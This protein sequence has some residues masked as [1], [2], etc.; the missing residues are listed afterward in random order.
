L[1]PVST[2]IYH[3][4]LT[5]CFTGTFPIIYLLPV[6]DFVFAEVP[7]SADS[8]PKMETIVDMCTAMLILVRDGLIDPSTISGNGPTN[9][10]DMWGNELAEEI[11]FDMRDAHRPEHERKLMSSRET[12]LIRHYPIEQVGVDEVLRVTWEIRQ[13]RVLATMEGQN[14]DDVDLGP[15]DGQDTREKAL[16]AQF[17]NIM[18]T[19]GNNLVARWNLNQVQAPKLPKAENVR[20]S[21]T[22]G[23]QLFRQYASNMMDSDAAANVAK[24]SSNIS[25]AAKVRWSSPVPASA[26]AALKEDSVESGQSAWS[27]KA[28]SLWGS[29]ASVARQ[30]SVNLGAAAAHVV[31]GTPPQEDT[32]TALPPRVTTPTH[33]PARSASISGANLSRRD[34]SLPPSFFIS[35]R[36]SIVYPAGRYRPKTAQNESKPSL[37]NRLAAAATNV[38][39]TRLPAEKERAGIKP[40]MLS[41]SARPASPASRSASVKSAVSGRESPLSFGSPGS[42]HGLDIEYYVPRK[43]SL[44][45]TSGDHSIP[46]SSVG[47]ARNGLSRRG[48]EQTGAKLRTATSNGIGLGRPSRQNSVELD[49][50][51]VTMPSTT[52]NQRYAL[53]D[54]GASRPQSPVE[55]DKPTGEAR[56]YQLSDA[57]VELSKT[58]PADMVLADSPIDAVPASTSGITRK[59][60][61]SVRPSGLRLKT[62]QS[63]EELRTGQATVVGLTRNESIS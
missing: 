59:G 58:N 45:R 25:A 50:T 13:Q 1:S 54:P 21:L 42:A 34:T 40:L 10:K 47:A 39:P 31:P 4:W 24:A 41:S 3:R 61:V 22:S 30:A 23:E 8:N 11:V 56:R 5:T 20:H 12:E 35:P 27:G 32:L 60:K 2:D 7:A 52:V 36:G 62:A 6:L 48:I 16:A 43:I 38:P 46:V 55:D 33:G 14:L 51:G 18:S 28:S 63:R 44:R 15:L 57:P 9:R 26:Q 29:V 53:A 19:A 49:D 37:Q 17:S